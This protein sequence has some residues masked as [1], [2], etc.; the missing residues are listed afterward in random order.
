MR[1]GHVNERT[2]ADLHDH[3]NGVPALPRGDS[4]HRRPMCAR[5]KLH[6]TSRGHNFPRHVK[7]LASYSD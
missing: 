5:A 6:K 1:L 7:V 3:V 2:V 4:L